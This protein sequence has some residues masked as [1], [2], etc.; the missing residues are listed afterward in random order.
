MLVVR[1]DIEKNKDNFRKIMEALADFNIESTLWEGEPVNL[2]VK[3]GQ[4]GTDLS[5]AV[6][7]VINQ[8]GRRGKL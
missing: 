5:S 3:S 8:L 4:T 1:I 7:S 2:E 6:S